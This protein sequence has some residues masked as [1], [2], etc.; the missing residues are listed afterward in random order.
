M[1]ETH[2]LPESHSAGDPAPS[3]A[4]SSSYRGPAS[5]RRPGSDAPSPDTSLTL[6]E[7]RASPAPGGD[8]PRP[9][10]STRPPPRVRC[11]RRGLGADPGDAGGSRAGAGSQDEAS[12]SAP[13]RSGL[14][15]SSYR[16]RDGSVSCF[17]GMSRGNGSEASAP[18]PPPTPRPARRGTLGR[19]AGSALTSSLAGHSRCPGSPWQRGCCRSSA[20]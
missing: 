18:P 11:R 9:P 15:C 5:Q 2:S 14:Q 3:P 4:T 7:P 16:R 17:L 20:A 1:K 10:S 13:S 19:A 8:P 6:S 12:D